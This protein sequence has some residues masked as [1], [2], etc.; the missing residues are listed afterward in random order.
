MGKKS[1]IERLLT[2]RLKTNNY[3]KNKMRVDFK[4][5]FLKFLLQYGEYHTYVEGMVATEWEYRMYPQ[6][7]LFDSFSWDS[8]DYNQYEW[9]DLNNRWL[10]LCKEKTNGL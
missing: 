8:T 7:F 5:E 9:E 3:D 4:K 10:K 2:A 6:N 1:S